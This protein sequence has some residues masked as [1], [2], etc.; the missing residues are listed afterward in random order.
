MFALDNVCISNTL[1]IRK[2]W[3]AL[4]EDSYEGDG[5]M[6]KSEVHLLTEK[7]SKQTIYFTKF[8]KERCKKIM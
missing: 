8:T 2:C 5:L 1:W 6:V 4:E 3:L 7:M